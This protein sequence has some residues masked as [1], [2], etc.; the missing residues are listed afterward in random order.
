MVAA[1]VALLLVIVVFLPGEED[2]GEPGLELAGNELLIEP[3]AG[4]PGTTI[5]VF[6]GPCE[7]P[8]GWT[9]GEISFGLH[10]PRARDEASRN[11]DTD[12]VTL[13]PGSPWRG[14]LTVPATASPGP[15]VVYANCWAADP[16][17]RWSRLHD[18]ESA[19]FT[20]E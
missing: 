18:Y 14:Q 10:D 8:D 7:R 6:G 2:S 5:E 15:Y 17:G 16:N 12:E 13:E 11:P 3:D 1:A 9:S 20:V 4:L 19:T